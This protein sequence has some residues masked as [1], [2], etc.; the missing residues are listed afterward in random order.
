MGRV[1]RSRARHV[2]PLRHPRQP[3]VH[4]VWMPPHRTRLRVDRAWRLARRAIRLA[5]HARDV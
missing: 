4:R 3:P 2:R 5:P 1:A